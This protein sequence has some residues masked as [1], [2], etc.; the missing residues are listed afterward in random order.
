MII[1]SYME[2]HKFIE[3]NPNSSILDTSGPSAS[4]I[5]TLISPDPEAVLDK[6]AVGREMGE[7]VTFEYFSEG[8]VK[9]VTVASAVRYKDTN[10]IYLH[11]CL[12]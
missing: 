10:M 1:K 8:E 5:T 11:V 4:Y 7:T 9:T 3:Y 2:G 6:V 12:T